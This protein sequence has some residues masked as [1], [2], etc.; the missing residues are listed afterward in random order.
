MRLP[1]KLSALPVKT[2]HHSVSPALWLRG[3]L[4][5]TMVL[6]LAACGHEDASSLS[7][8]ST[9]DHAAVVAEEPQAALVGRD[10]LAEGGNPVDA[11]VAMGLALSVTLPS[12]AGLLGGGRCLVLD[13]ASKQVTGFDFRPLPLPGVD[14]GRSVYGAPGMLRGLFAMQARFGSLRF[15]QLVS[16]AERLA[17]FDG[18][19]SR[20]LHG[21]M[22]AF[23]AR[24]GRIANPVWQGASTVQVGEGLPWDVMAGALAVLRQEGPGPFYGGRIGR[25]LAKKLA[26]DESAYAATQP[27]IAEAPYAELSGA[28]RAYLSGGEQ[29]QELLRAM[30]AGKPLPALTGD[31]P[32]ATGIVVKGRD[33][34]TV[35]CG[36]TLGQAFGVGEPVGEFG[37]LPARAVARDTAMGDGLLGPVIV[38]NPNVGDLRLA[39]TVSGSDSLPA[40]MVAA[41]AAILKAQA[42]GGGQI[43]AALQPLDHAAAA[44]TAP[45]RTLVSCSTAPRSDERHCGAGLEP[46][47]AGLAITP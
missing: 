22:Q 45:R 7:Q 27:V 25:Q 47:V 28:D 12:R 42:S 33:D 36:F 13:P 2:V 26:L 6:A 43:S 37:L 9:A 40:P 15:A 39:A 14:G 29:E 11:A 35:A 41:M 4:V 19:V 46:G 5:S 20:G 31:A 24:L 17:R 16:P 34:F 1:P 23:G 44:D 3:M 30:I 38:A 21:D 32:P 8:F 18:V 10:I